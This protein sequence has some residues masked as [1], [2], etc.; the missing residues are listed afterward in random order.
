M[1]YKV[2]DSSLKHITIT[3]GLHT[4]RHTSF[5]IFSRL[6]ETHGLFHVSNITSLRNRRLGQIQN[7]LTSLLEWFL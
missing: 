2:L 3:G 5:V 4:V 6:D 7:S 1:P